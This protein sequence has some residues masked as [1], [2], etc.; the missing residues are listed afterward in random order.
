MKYDTS[1]NWILPKDAT[2]MIKK[3]IIVSKPDLVGIKMNTRN[4]IETSFN[5]SHQ[6]EVLNMFEEQ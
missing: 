3:R 5:L 4:L 2:Q 1:L 6:V